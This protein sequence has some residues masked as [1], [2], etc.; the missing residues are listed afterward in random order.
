MAYNVWQVS[1][2]CGATAEQI[3]V[4]QVQSEPDTRLLYDRS[5][6]G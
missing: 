6:K 2:V 4:E 3:W 5:L 1:E